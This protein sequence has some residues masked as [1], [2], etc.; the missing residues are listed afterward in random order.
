MKNITWNEYHSWGCLEDNEC[1]YFKAGIANGRDEASL[2]QRSSLDY[3]Q[4]WVIT[5][6]LNLECVSELMHMQH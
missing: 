5:L 3:L 2:P 6:G 4:F 1:V